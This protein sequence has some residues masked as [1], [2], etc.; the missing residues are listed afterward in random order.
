MQ[1][2]AQVLW[3]AVGILFCVPAVA[4]TVSKRPLDY[5]LMEYG[6]I[7]GVAMVGGFVAWVSRVRRGEAHLSG[8]LGLIGEMVTSAFAGLITF[9]LCEYASAPS[10]LTAALAGIA[11]HMGPR[12]I[13]IIEEGLARKMGIKVPEGLK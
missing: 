5:P 2:V 13:F 9:W 7:L 12:A 10:L 3:L 4:E 8:L 6:L 1:R 11:G